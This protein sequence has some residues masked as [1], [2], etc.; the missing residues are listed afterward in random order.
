MRCHCLT[1]SKYLI[2]SLRNLFVVKT[3]LLYNWLVSYFFQV[4]VFQYRIY[5]ELF[6]PVGCIRYTQNKK[7]LVVLLPFLEV[8]IVK[9]YTMKLTTLVSETPRKRIKLLI[10]EQQLKTLASNIIREQEEGAIKKTYLIK[11]NTNGKKK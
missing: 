3:W 9:K 10:S 6:L 11:Q 1:N 8:F 5:F 7:K 4:G 2:C